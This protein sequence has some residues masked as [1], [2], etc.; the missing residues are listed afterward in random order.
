MTL[1]ASLSGSVLIR[2]Y[3]T[4]RTPGNQYLDTVGVDQLFIRVVP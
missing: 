4:D 3:D 2:V 1:H